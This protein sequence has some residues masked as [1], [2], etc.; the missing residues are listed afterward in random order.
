MKKSLSNTRFIFLRAFA[1]LIAACLILPSFADKAGAFKVDQRTLYRNDSGESYWWTHMRC[2][3][4]PSEPNPQILCTVSKDPR[5]NPNLSDVFYDIAYA[6]SIDLGETW[7]PLSVIP[8]Y[9]WKTLPD[10]YDGMLID[11]VPVYH[12]ESGK[13]ILFGMA[14]S[15]EISSTSVHKKHNYPAYAVYDPSTDEWSGDW[16]IFDWP[17]TYGHTGSVYPHVLEDGSGDIL[18]P[19]NPLDGSGSIRVMRVSFD[20]TTLDYQSQSAAIVNTGGNGNRSGIE[21]S[22]TAFDNSYFIAM[23]DDSQNRLAASAD[24]ITW[25]PAVPLQW[26]DGT[27]VAGSMN[28][29]MHWIARP[30][31]LYLVYTRQDVSNADIFRYRAPLWMAEVNPDTLRLKKETERVVMGITSDRAQLGNFG[32]TDI[33]PQLSIVTSNEWNSLAPNRAIVSRIWWEQTQLGGWEF[34]EGSGA[35]VHD[36]TLNGYDGTVIG[37]SRAAGGKF[38]GALQF[39][40]SGYADLGDPGDE[41]FDFG[42][43]QN[44]TVSVWAKTDSTGSIQYVLNKGDTNAAYWLRFKADG[45]LRFLLDYGS[46]YDD[47]QSASS[48]ADG[49]W[50]HVAGV[51]DRNG[52][53]RLY[54]DGQLADENTSLTGGSVSNSLPLT[55][56]FNGSS[57]M[58]GLIDRAG[59]YDYAMDELEIQQLTCMAGHWTLDGI[60]AGGLAYDSTASGN[61]GALHGVMTESSGKFGDALRF[62]EAGAYVDLGLPEDGAFDFGITEDFSISAWVKSSGGGVQY[63]AN[64]GTT[65]A[66]YWLR[67]ETDGTLRFLLDYGGTADYAQSGSGYADNQW[68]HV[69]G[70]ADRDQNVKLY[71]DGVLAGQSTG[72]TGGNVSSLHPLTIGTNSNNTMN[73]LIDEFRLYRYALSEEDVLALFNS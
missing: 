72:V 21:P 3:A 30:D 60:I 36:L 33:S 44:F 53:L 63:I 20:G 61:D 52:G 5:E 45:T 15:Y 11:P 69:V 42:H 16:Q 51:A 24:G 43:Q 1:L 46:T 66:A 56:G 40:G 47:V 4:I 10:G 9:Q 29:Q 14:Q 55:I 62:P 23:R 64:K 49:I 71:V 57:S 65:N 54:V 58:N 67:F 13:I 26:E 50:H 59:L 68:H 37:A 39:D 32:V 31:K 17:G 25:Q 18:W 34:D 27:S 7:T 19:V 22:I 28:T 70:T 6:T 73:G 41:A 2:A 35:T 48:Y 38:G 8:Q 12:E